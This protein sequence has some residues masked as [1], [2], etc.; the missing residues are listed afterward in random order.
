MFNDSSNEES[1]FAKKKW[2]V[3]DSQ[4][5]KDKYNQN[6]SIKFETESI[7]S[8][9]WD[10]S[11]AF[12]L[13]TGDIT[14]NAPFSTCKAEI[15][16]VFFWWSKSY[17]YCNAMYNLIEYSYNYSGTSGSLW[18][19]KR[20][21]VPDN[22]VDL[23]LD[24]P[25]SFKYKAALV[26][27][28]TNA[29]N[30]TNSSVKNTKIVVPLKYLSNFWRSLEMP[31]INCKIRLELNWI[32]DDILS[33]AGDSAKFKI[34]DAK[35][36][37]TI[38]TLS[39][40]DNVNL[41]E[42]LSSGLKRSVYWNSYQTIPAKVINKG[43]NVYELLSASFQGVKILFVFPYVIAAGAANN[44][45]GIKDNR[46]YFLPRQKIENYNILID[47]R[48]FYGQPINDLLKQNDEVR[49]V[50]TGQGDDYTTRYLLDYAHFEDNYRLIVVDLSKQ[51]AFDVDP[52]AIQQIVFQE[53]AGGADSTKIRLFLKN[54]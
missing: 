39:A 12:I 15:N 3:I 44:E 43:A 24:N 26:G 7:K 48:S 4:T 40:K 18:Q 54:K 42:Q 19:F 35:L 6:N 22:N 38:V 14:V 27:K 46:K 2:Y 52:R 20:E 33:S 49:K 34:R 36:H 28:T 16:D 1:K 17:L 47:R 25:Q 50:S 37:V 5:A 45:T 13:V 21:E 23:T 51:K 8:S 9:I 53:V 41:T 30:N 10:Y 11:E 31:L 29:V 32:E